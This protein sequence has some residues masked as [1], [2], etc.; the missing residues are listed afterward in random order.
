MEGVANEV[1]LVKPETFMN[2]SGMAVKQLVEEYETGSDDLLVIYDELDLPLGAIRIRER[3]S[4]AGHNGMQ[5]VLNALGTP[6]IPRVR[7]GISPEHAVKDGARYVLHPWK[8]S[9]LEAV[10]EQLERAA[11]AVEMVL[12]QGIGKAMNFYNRRPEA[13]S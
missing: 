7:L 13:A 12:K 5:S 6:E 10:D 2:L 9:Q 1:L 4:A 11:D 8:K 3:G